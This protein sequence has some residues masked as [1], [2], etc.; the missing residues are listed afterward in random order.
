MFKVRNIEI[1]YL[2]GGA[3][4]HF[5]GTAK[6][7]YNRYRARRDRSGD[8]QARARSRSRSDMNS[9]GDSRSTDRRGGR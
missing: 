4:G 5:H 7:S 3:P 6:K 9:P 2:R 1:P 8:P